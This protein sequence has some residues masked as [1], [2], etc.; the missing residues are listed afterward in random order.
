[1]AKSDWKARRF[2][3]PSRDY[4]DVGVIIR[5]VESYLGKRLKGGD[6][7]VVMPYAEMAQAFNAYISMLQKM[8]RKAA[9]LPA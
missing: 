8:D 7:Y 4:P 6:G 1:M 9:Q 3:F 5:G 2:F